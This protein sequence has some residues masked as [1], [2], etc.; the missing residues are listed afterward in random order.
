MAIEEGEKKRM[1]ELRQNIK[2]ALGDNS[3][4]DSFLQTIS[5]AFSWKKKPAIKLTNRFWGFTLFIS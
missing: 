1:K 3:N 4:C 2:K 5:K